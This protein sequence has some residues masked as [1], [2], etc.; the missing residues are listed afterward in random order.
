MANQKNKKRR[1]F[2]G[3]VIHSSK[4]AGQSPGSLGH[5]ETPDTKQ[6]EAKIQRIV[7]SKEHLKIEHEVDI[8]KLSIPDSEEIFEWI[9]VSSTNDYK[10][11]KKI[12]EIF[13]IHSLILEDISNPEQPPKL[14]SFENARFIV[15]TNFIYDPVNQIMR[16]EQLY[17]YYRKNYILTFSNSPVTQFSEILKR[18]EDPAGRIRTHKPDYLVYVILDHVI[19]SYFVCLE[20][21]GLTLDNLEIQALEETDENIMKEIHD[22]RRELLFARKTIWP[23]RDII[24]KIETV[25]SEFISSFTRPFMRDLY[26][27]TVQASELLETYREII[28]GL[29]ELVLSL[30]SHRMNDIMKVLTVFAAIFIPL[31]FIVGIYGMN[32]DYMPELKWKWGYFGIWGI[33]IGLSAGMFVYFKKKKWF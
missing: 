14:D 22:I 5:R 27:H 28:V 26:D 24:R 1:T 8:N 10:T 21:I 6:P 16:H 4:K 31:T 7:Y 33:M 25:N 29:Q 2:S 11:L 9:H 30:Q 32:F 17:M 18:L 19:D 12:G 3:L 13:N 23:M 20:K 15:T